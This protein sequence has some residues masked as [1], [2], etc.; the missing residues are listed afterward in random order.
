MRAMAFCAIARPVSIDPVKLSAVTAGWLT[1]VSPTTDP[2]PMTRL[3]TPA[4]T[5]AFARISVSAHAHPGV[6]CAGLNTTV[7][8]N[9]SAGAI[10]H[11]GMAIGKFHGVIS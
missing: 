7:L 10:F 2:E 3:N 6:H 5:P 11:A 4:G 8:P 9:A 1:I